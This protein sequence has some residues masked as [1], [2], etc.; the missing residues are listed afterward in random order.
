M[1]A[2]E[3]LLRD[4]PGFSEEQAESALQAAERPQRDR[5]RREEIDGAIV[6]GY[7]RHPA[8]VPDATVRELAEASIRAEPW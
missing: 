5:T 6:E 4:A 7:E 1:T 8:E 2:K 3:K